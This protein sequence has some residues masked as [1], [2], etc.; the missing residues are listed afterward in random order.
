MKPG[1]YH[2]EDL[3]DYS[4]Y[5]SIYQGFEVYSEYNPIFNEVGDE[6]DEDPFPIRHTMLNWIEILCVSPDSRG[7]NVGYQLLKTLEEYLLANFDTNNIV[8]GLDVVGTKK[9]FQNLSLR[10]YY[11]N[12]GFKFPQTGFHEHHSG[13]QLAYNI[14]KG[15]LI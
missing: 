2:G 12:L 7:K 15:E 9:R 5:I 8:I 13:A 14:I 11:S 10:N 6:I 3:Y 4:K 1:Y